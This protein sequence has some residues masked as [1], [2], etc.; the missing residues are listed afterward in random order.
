[1]SSWNEWEIVREVGFRVIHKIEKTHRQKTRKKR[2][3]T[4]K[5]KKQKKTKINAKKK[6]KKNAKN[7]KKRKPRKN[8]KKTLKILIFKVS[9]FFSFFHESNANSWFFSESDVLD[10]VPIN[11]TN[12]NDVSPSQPGF[13]WCWQLWLHSDHTCSTFSKNY[14]KN[15]S[16]GNWFDPS[17]E[18]GFYNFWNWSILQRTW[19]L[20][21]QK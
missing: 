16:L 8:A 13:L 4:R 10:Q 2:E 15:S 3:K 9:F 21:V 20:F 7:E 12:C 18:S 17:S 5:T 14:V 1:M 19:T 6:R 11:T